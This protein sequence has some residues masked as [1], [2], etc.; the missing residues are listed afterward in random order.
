MNYRKLLV[1][2]G[3]K[4]LDKKLSSEWQMHAEIYKNYPNYNAIVHTHSPI[5]TAFAVCNKKIP[6]ILIEMEA[7]LGGEIEVHPFT[8]QALLNL[9]NLFSLI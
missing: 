7:F 8:R 4:L 1:K 2:Y 5:A 3:K 6:R 9:Q